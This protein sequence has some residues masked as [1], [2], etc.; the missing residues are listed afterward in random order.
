MSHK[1]I[2]ILLVFIIILLKVD[3][4]I[5][6]ALI[7]AFLIT[8]RKTGFQ[9]NRHTVKSQTQDDKNG[10]TDI[11]SL[12]LPDYTKV[13]NTE[14]YINEIMG[15]SADDR[16]SNLQMNSSQKHKNS[17]DII[18]NKTSEQSKRYY[19]TEFEQEENR[20]WWVD[21]EYELSKKFK[22]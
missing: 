8:Y 3:V 5:V 1:T 11:P 15:Y 22:I 21:D 18:A 19:A 9:P 6:I 10:L 4:N 16:I 7:I 14:Q 17:L 20:D 2:F 12:D 13:D